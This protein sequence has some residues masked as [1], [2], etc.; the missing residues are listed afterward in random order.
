M[1]RRP[2]PLLCELHAHTTWSDGAFALPELVDMY[3]RA[4]FDVLA[5]TDHVNR[6]DDPLLPPHASPRGVVAATQDAYLADIDAEAARARTEYDLLVLPGVELSYNDL[7]PLLAAHAVAV[8]LRTFAPLD[9]GLDPALDRAREE[10]A[11]LIAAHPFRTRRSVAPGR[12]TLRFARDWRTLRD[13]I[14]RWELFNRYDLFGWVAECGLPAVATGDF[15]RPE[16]LYGWKTLL[17]C[18]K[19]DSSVVEYLRSDR[20]TF[21]TRIDPPHELRHAA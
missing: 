5:V 21:L 6:P 15:H 12:A 16:H 7:D 13:R 3:G 10:G 14:D 9:G 19:D 20:P 11:A 17:P 2:E 8:G 4:G 1:R 18:R